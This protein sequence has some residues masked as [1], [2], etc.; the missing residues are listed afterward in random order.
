MTNSQNNESPNAAIAAKL[1][2]I[3]KAVPPKGRH[4]N[5]RWFT[6]SSLTCFRSHGAIPWTSCGA[7]VDQVYNR[8]CELAMRRSR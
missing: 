5:F 4:E 2:S 8:A 6:D 1:R 7:R 3:A